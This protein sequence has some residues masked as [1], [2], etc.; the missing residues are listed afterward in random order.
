MVRWAAVGNG[1]AVS[2][3]GHA[4]GPSPVGG[5]QLDDGASG[6]SLLVRA[7]IAS[8][9]R[10]TNWR[11][12]QDEPSQQGCLMSSL[13][14][15]GL[16]ACS[17]GAIATLLCPSTVGHSNRAKHTPSPPPP[18]DQSCRMRLMA[19]GYMPFRL[20]A[21]TLSRSGLRAPSQ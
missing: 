1:W 10:T 19:A 4:C 6:L 8:W 11:T 21:G 15:Q 13:S 3:S 2:S 5:G 18:S 12:A 9:A 17:A 20:Q 16:A 7:L 14:V